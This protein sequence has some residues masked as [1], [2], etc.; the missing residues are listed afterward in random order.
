MSFFWHFLQ[1]SNGAVHL[2]NLWEWSI[3]YDSFSAPH[4][5]AA[6]TKNCLKSTFKIKV[7]PIKIQMVSCTP[8]IVW[9]WS[10]YCPSLLAMFNSLHSSMNQQL[11]EKH[12]CRDWLDLIYYYPLGNQHEPFFPYHVHQASADPKTKLYTHAQPKTYQYLNS[13][14]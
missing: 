3:H 4:C 14:I 7:A 1:C 6:W 8:V 12:L 9:N 11:F 5:T 2:N 10:I 13:Y